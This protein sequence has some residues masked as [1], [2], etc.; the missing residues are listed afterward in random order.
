MRRE[1]KH[2]TR[3][4]QLSKKEGGREGNEGQKSYDIQKTVRKM[5]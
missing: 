3:K 4:N 5:Q 1:S 2:V